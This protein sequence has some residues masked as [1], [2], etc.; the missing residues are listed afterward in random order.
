MKPP[1]VRPIVVED[2][3]GPAFF[4][5]LDANV[6]L[7]SPNRLDDVQLVQFGFKCML[8]TPQGVLTS[9]LTPDEVATFSAVRVGPPC[10][11][12]EDDPLVRAIRA[13]EKFT[14]GQQDGRV[15]VKP[16][17]A[18]FYGGTHRFIIIGLVVAIRDLTGDTFPRFDRHPD[19]QSGAALV[20]SVLRGCNQHF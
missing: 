20:K 2:T 18:N 8:K 14:G 9:P 3:G 16:P 17:N 13:H 12:R 5:N 10:T 4:W 11:G 1:M 19:C 6:G 15:T 7:N